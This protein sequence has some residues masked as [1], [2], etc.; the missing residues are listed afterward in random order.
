MLDIAFEMLGN[1]HRRR[2]LLALK[3][4]N[5]RDDV[6]IPEEIHTGDEDLELLQAEMYH[7]HL[8]KLEAAGYI[9]WDRETHEVVKGPKFDEI[10]PILRLLD[11]H[12]DELPDGWP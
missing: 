7:T 12:A 11:E 10:R 8:P 6:T 4:R 1:P 2:L 9:S 3:E 5:P